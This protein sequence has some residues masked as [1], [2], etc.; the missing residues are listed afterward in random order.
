MILSYGDN[1]VLRSFLLKG[2]FISQNELETLWIN[3]IL[4]RCE[5]VGGSK[6]IL[7]KHQ[8]SAYTICGI[9]RSYE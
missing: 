7:H 3:R 5:K 1:R 2:G 4:E 6:Q 9:G 8:I